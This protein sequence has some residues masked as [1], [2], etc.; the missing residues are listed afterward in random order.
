MCFSYL[1]SIIFYQFGWHLKSIYSLRPIKNEILAFAKKSH[2]KCNLKKIDLIIF[3][4]KW[5]DL[6]C[7]PK[8]NAFGRLNLHSFMG[9]R[10]Y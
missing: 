9:R 3:L 8:L 6:I 7:M 2:K 1:L 4:I 5:S 10:E